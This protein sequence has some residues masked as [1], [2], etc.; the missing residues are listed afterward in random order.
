VASLIAELHDDEVPSQLTARHRGGGSPGPESNVS[1]IGLPT[2]GAWFER[3]VEAGNTV[4]GRR[5][6][7]ESRWWRRAT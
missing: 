4:T 1:R 7:W 6:W 3:A 5:L 2:Y